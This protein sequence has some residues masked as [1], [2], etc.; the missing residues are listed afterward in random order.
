[1]TF[2]APIICFFVGHDER[3][4]MHEFKGLFIGG[5]QKIHSVPQVQC[6]RCG[7]FKHEATKKWIGV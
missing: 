4:F 2:L 7:L 6:N 3:H 5:V 1:M